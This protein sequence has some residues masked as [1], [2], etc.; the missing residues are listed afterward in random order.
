MAGKADQNWC[1]AVESVEI[2]CD[3][4]K[5]DPFITSGDICSIFISITSRLETFMLLYLSIGSGGLLII[6][7]LRS[8]SELNIRR[9]LLL[10]LLQYLRIGWLLHH[11]KNWSDQ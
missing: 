3:D 1:K 7:T 6:L 8:L 2:P 11:Q 4:N 10:K 5:D 9:T